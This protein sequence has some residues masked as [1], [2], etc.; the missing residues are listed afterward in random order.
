MPTELKAVT[1]EARQRAQDK[2][3][4]QKPEQ[5][6]PKTIDEPRAE[7][8]QLLTDIEL[9]RKLVSPNRV[10]Q[11]AQEFLTRPRPK[12]PDE[13][14][15]QFAK[16]ATFY[17]ITRNTLSEWIGRIFRKE[18]TLQSNPEFPDEIKNNFDGNH[19][20]F[21][22]FAEQVTREVCIGGR[23][24]LTIV[25]GEDGKPRAGLLKTEDVIDWPDSERNQVVVKTYVVRKNL[26]I[27]AYLRYVQRENFIEVRRFVKKSK[28]EMEKD[29]NS[30]KGPVYTRGFNEEVLDNIESTTLPF[31]PVTASG[32][33]WEIS[34]IPLLPIGEKDIRYYNLLARLDWSLKEATLVLPWLAGVDVEEARKRKSGQAIVTENQEVKGGFVEAEGAAIQVLRES[35]LD[36]EQQLKSSGAVSPDSK[37][38]VETAETSRLREAAQTSILSEVV[39][40]TN[41]GLTEFIYIIATYYGGVLA[42]LN[43]G[44]FTYALNKDLA[45]TRIPTSDLNFFERLVEKGR[46][47]QDVFIDILNEAEQL[48]ST[49]NDEKLE[50]LRNLQ[51][52]NVP[53]STSPIPTAGSDGA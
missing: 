20:S 47:P 24:V 52:D 42:T 11:A 15:D 29:P 33:S 22:D 16:D 10:K 18:V 21:D 7:L 8:K 1:A 32:V 2:A 51:V 26:K 48:P 31:V 13:E 4:S 14:F 23:P 43:R 45:S 9:L 12:M 50:E 30:N 41:L 38:G 37:K 36:L 44:D 40:G 6:R 34:S 27:E 5:A 46:I 39:K 35:I 17:H 3:K 28:A 25:D 53:A 49:I 19:K